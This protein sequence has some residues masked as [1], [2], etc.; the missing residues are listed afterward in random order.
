M[1][2]EKL[3]HHVL[4]GMRLFVKEP[5][6]SCFQEGFLAALE[7][8]LRKIDD[9]DVPG[10]IFYAGN[11]SGHFGLGA[12]E[13]RKLPIEVS[14]KQ[15]SVESSKMRHGPGRAK[16]RAD[17]NKKLREYLLREL[18]VKDDPSDS[19]Y[20]YGWC[21]ALEEVRGVMNYVPSYRLQ[22]KVSPEPT[23]EARV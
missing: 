16:Q 7:A 1:K 9:A 3:R 21:C 22:Y 2:L 4:E 5:P 18:N 19:D 20:I 11:S 17:A 6:D 14:D 13:V 12:D 23:G 8:V 10:N 15:K